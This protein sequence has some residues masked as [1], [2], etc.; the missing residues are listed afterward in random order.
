MFLLVSRTLS[1]SKI[2][3]KYPI[4]PPKFQKANFGTLI[5][6]WGTPN[7]SL[8]VLYDRKLS[9]GSGPSIY[10]LKVCEAL[11]L[12]DEFIK[13]AKSVHNSIQNK[14]IKTSLYNKSVILEKCKI[15]KKK[16]SR[17]NTSYSRTM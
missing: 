15:C 6:C 17:G 4:W 13:I 12:S 10:G 16:F 14:T 3:K 8:K 7:N 5:L 1:W 2:S 11:G 9:E